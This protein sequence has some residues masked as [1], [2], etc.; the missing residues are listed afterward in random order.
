MTNE[1]T[2]FTSISTERG[3]ATA[4]YA[5]ATVAAAGFAGLL[6]VVLKSS[7]IQNLL[8]DLISGALS[9]VS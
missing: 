4:E 9:F 7:P 3:A 8:T 1:F 6:A 5:I 2:S